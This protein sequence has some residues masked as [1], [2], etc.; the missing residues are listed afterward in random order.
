VQT[1]QAAVVALRQ[2]QQFPAASGYFLE[3]SK[4]E[5]VQR[6]RFTG[7]SRVSAELLLPARQEPSLSEVTTLAVLHKGSG[8][9]YLLHR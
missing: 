2:T 7:G 5:E 8:L 6:R 3:L 1:Q 4:E 9:A